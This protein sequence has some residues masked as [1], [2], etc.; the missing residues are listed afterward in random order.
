VVVFC[1]KI[2]SL[3][4]KRNL[5]KEKLIIKKLYKICLRQPINKL[6]RCELMYWRFVLLQKLWVW[7]EEELTTE[8]IKRIVL[9][10]VN[11][12]AIC[13]NQAILI[14]LFVLAQKWKIELKI[15]SALPQVTWQQ[16]F[17]TC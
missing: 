6:S 12:A 15:C 11:E 7:A 8:E 10:T 1:G 4:E 13:Q 9:A 2:N 14:S 17:T 3:Q 16:C 5:A